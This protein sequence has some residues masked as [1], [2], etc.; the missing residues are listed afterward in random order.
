MTDKKSMDYAIKLAHFKFSLIAPVI[1]GNFLDPS[2]SAY[3]KRVTEKPLARP[4]GTTFPYRPKTLESWEQGY[5]KGGMDALMPGTR[6]DKGAPRKLPDTAMAEIYR[7]KEKFP[8]LNAAQIHLYLIREGF[9]TS[10]TSLR[11]VQRFIKAFNLKSGS[12]GAVRDRKAFEETHFGAMFQ[13]DSCFFPHITENGKSRRTFL[14]MIVD[15]YSRMIVGAKLFYNDNAE[16]FQILLKQAVS[17]YGICDKLYCDWGG[18][19]PITNSR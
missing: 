10:K 5:R 17:T 11:C 18:L 19:I 13:A 16:N 12:A 8:R 1:Q 9:I 15:D 7:L 6:S 3:Y 14:M 2:K 4:D